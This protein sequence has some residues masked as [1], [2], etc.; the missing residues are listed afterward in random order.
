MNRKDIM[1]NILKRVGAYFI[2]LVIITAILSFLTSVDKINYQYKNYQKYYKDYVKT[3]EKYTKVSNKKLHLNEK[4]QNK[5]IKKKKYQNNKKK[6]DNQIKKYEN[7]IKKIQYNMSRYSII[8]NIM[9]IAFILGYF[10]IFQA[11]NNGQTLGKKLMK[12]K[13]V[14]KDGS[15]IKIW[16][17]LI[18]SFI[19]FSV[20]MYIANIICIYTF[21]YKGYYTANLITSE[22]S[23]TLNLVTLLMVILTKQGRGIHDYIARTRVILDSKDSDVVEGEIIN[24]KG[25]K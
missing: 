18:R 24:N 25:D 12:L 2:D 7:D 14:S 1:K 5:I 19:L 16:Q 8:S 3:T 11:T 23:R 21:N 22:I 13:V 4:Y 10:G 9:Y 20:W 15:N 17:A 6:L